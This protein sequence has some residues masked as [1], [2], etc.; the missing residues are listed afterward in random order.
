[1]SLR[2]NVDRWQARVRFKNH[3]AWSFG[4]IKSKRSVLVVSRVKV[5]SGNERANE[6]F[7]RRK[8]ISQ[9]F[10]CEHDGRAAVHCEEFLLDLEI[11]LQLKRPDWPRVDPEGDES[12][13]S[14]RV[15]D[16]RA[17]SLPRNGSYRA[18]LVDPG[19]EAVYENRTSGW[20]RYCGNKNAVVAPCSY[21]RNRAAGEA[22]EAVGLKPLCFRRW[23]NIC[24]HFLI[25]LPFGE[26]TCNPELLVG[27][28]FC[29]SVVACSQRL[30]DRA[31]ARPL[32]VKNVLKECG[33][34]G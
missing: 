17:V 18:G 20:R 21:A 23:S 6:Q 31:E 7:H 14:V 1:M 16:S 22:A 13:C 11:I 24:G 26:L 32:S 9:N 33:W 8:S 28:R 34:L 2:S 5:P 12:G 27:T 4:C 10:P 29:A 19:F 30:P 3:L 15:D 25:S